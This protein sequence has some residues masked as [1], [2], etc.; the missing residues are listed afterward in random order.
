MLS[1][2]IHHYLSFFVVSSHP[3]SFIPTSSVC[4]PGLIHIEMKR[5][6]RSHSKTCTSQFTDCS[7]V[8]ECIIKDYSN[9]CRIGNHG[10]IRRHRTNSKREKL[11]SSKQKKKI[12]SF[13]LPHF[14]IN[15]FFV[16]SVFTKYACEYEVIR[17]GFFNQ[18]PSTKYLHAILLYVYLSFRWCG[19][20]IHLFS[21]LSPPN[22]NNFGEYIFVVWNF[23]C[24]HL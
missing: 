2:N 7:S 6:E 9:G 14:I 22:A 23:V 18:L 8:S 5:L 12:S 17:I 11:S 24:G 15:H 16:Y 19:C 13:L 21:H 1:W 10:G 3:S 20:K 4:L